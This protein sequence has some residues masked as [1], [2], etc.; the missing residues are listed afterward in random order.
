[1]MQWHGIDNT[2][3][4]F[5]RFDKSKL[6]ENESKLCDRIVLVFSNRRRL[7]SEDSP[8]NRGDAKKI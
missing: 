6:T 2:Q 5:L 4:A 1:M 7:G 8:G 3:H